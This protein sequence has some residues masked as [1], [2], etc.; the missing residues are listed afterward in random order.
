MNDHG[1]QDDRDLE[2]ILKT[3]FCPI[4]YYIGQV[5]NSIPLFQTYIYILSCSNS[6][7]MN[8][9]QMKYF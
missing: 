1:K 7:S 4:K 6:L 9:E 8:L 2:P 3:K 5:L